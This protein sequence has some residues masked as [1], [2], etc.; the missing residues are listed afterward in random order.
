MRPILFNTE[1]VRAILEGRKTVT[2]RIVKPRPE[3]RL[4]PMLPGSCWPGCFA[5]EGT[6]KVVR[7]PYAPGGKQSRT[8][9][10]CFMKFEEAALKGGNDE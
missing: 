5:V 9:W 6:Q 10:G 2:R 4:I 1:M 8:F 7:P 3:G